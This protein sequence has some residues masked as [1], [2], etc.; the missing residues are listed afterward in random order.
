[1]SESIMLALTGGLL[2]VLG[3]V[4][5]IHLITNSPAGIGI[6]TS[7][8]VTLPTM[9]VA[10]VT[11]ALVGLLSAAIPSYRASRKNIVEGLRHI[12]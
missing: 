1:L 5:L 11:A 2:G 3:A 8:K 4:A 7:M 6:P 10:I 12:G 9:L